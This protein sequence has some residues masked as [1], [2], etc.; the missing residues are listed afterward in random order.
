MSWHPGCPDH[1]PV[2]RPG[3]SLPGLT[4]HAVRQ[5]HPT[6]SNSKSLGCDPPGPLPDCAERRRA[7]QQICSAP[8]APT[9]L[10]SRRSPLTIQL[11]E[12]ATNASTPYQLPSPPLKQPHPVQAHHESETAWLDRLATAERNSARLVS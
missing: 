6:E 7:P 3:T 1:V 12:P 5:P 2:P 4:A 11:P 10:A 8:M 9:D